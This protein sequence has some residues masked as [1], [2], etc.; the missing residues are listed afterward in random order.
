MKHHTRSIK[1]TSHALKS[2]TFEGSPLPAIA[3]LL[4]E[5]KRE[6]DIIA[7]RIKTIIIH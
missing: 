2:L 3:S 1:R 6:F 4:E 7:E 5:S